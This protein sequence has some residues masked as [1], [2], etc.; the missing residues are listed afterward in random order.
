MAGPVRKPRNKRSISRQ[1]IEHVRRPISL[2]H[3][4]EKW[5]RLPIDSERYRST[6]LSPPPYQIQRPLPQ[7]FPE[8]LNATYNRTPFSN[9][10]VQYP[11][12]IRM[13]RS[14]SRDS[15]TSDKSFEIRYNHT[16]PYY[17]DEEAARMVDA[18]F[19]CFSRCDRE[20][21]ELWGL[22]QDLVK[23]PP[24]VEDMML[25]NILQLT[26]LVFFG[27]TLR[28]RVRWKWSDPTQKRFETELIGTTAVRR[29]AKG[30]YETLIILSRP[31]LKHPDYDC[32][33]LLSTFL[34]ELV[35]CYLFIMVGTDARKNGWHTDG[36]QAIVN[37]IDTWAGS[38]FLRLCDMKADLD[39][40][41]QQPMGTCSR[42]TR[43]IKERLS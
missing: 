19:R 40:F 23:N 15:I 16:F 26:D 25:D 13:E 24:T 5:Q 14:P 10:K 6:S 42:S 12:C 34:H 35:H 17:D 20:E 8:S 27:G 22:I 33:L 38:G 30:G 21:S 31:I 4:R 2:V 36:F 43:S 11:D 41:S 9:T 37:T 39:Y 32:R 3:R 7:S 18:H 28:G 29:V 1:R